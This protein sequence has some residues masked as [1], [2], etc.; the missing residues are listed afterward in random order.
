VHS[1]IITLSKQVRILSDIVVLAQEKN[2]L[3]E[4][5]GVTG[6]KKVGIVEQELNF[7]LRVSERYGSM[8]DNDYFTRRVRV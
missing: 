5:Y 7:P 4:F 1:N 3:D 2:L 8:D 6:F